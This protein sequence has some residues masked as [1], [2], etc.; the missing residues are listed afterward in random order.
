MYEAKFQ[1]Q[2]CRAIRPR[3]DR[4]ILAGVAQMA[5]RRLCRYLA[6]PTVRRR[7]PSPEAQRRGAL[8]LLS[9]RSAE[10]CTEAIM[11]ARIHS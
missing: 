1:L 7:S 11:V 10:G 3:F 6:M 9:S 4:K 2:E 8:E 5:P